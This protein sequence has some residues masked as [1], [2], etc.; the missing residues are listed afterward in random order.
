MGE[1]VGARH[2]MHVD[3]ARHGGLPVVGGAGVEDEAEK[4]VGDETCYGQRS[5]GAACPSGCGGWGFARR[6]R[7]L[8][9][10]FRGAGGD[11]G[12]AGGA[13][14]GAD[15]NE[16]VDGETGGAGLGAF[17]AID[18]SVGIATDLDRA[19]ERDES[20]ER[21]IGAEVAAPEVL[22]QHGAE[23][24]H[25]D[26]DGGGEADVA[27]EVEHF[28]IREEAVGRGH[29]VG[30]GFGGHGPD[31]EG[32]EA[33]EEILQ[34][35]ER[36]VDPAVQVEVATEEA[37]AKDGEIFGEGADGA[38][39]RAE[40]L[41]E[42]NA[43]QDEGEEEKH[44]GGMDERNVAGGE[45]E[46]RVH[47]SGDGQPAFDASGARQIEALAS[48]FEVAHPNEELESEPAVERNKDELDDVADALGAVGGEAAHQR[49]LVLDDRFGAGTH[50][51]SLKGPR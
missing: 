18:A 47:E 38:E 1:L 27:E 50:R 46:L 35:A 13:L 4:D 25:A 30:Q 16:L 37:A 23:H 49:L 48:V 8:Q 51:T 44:R 39:P 2:Q 15:L 14:G 41:F 21:A 36:D 24:E 28:D 12:H 45:E 31:D 6:Q 40:G 7:K 17:G 20:H 29:E 11:A 3:L 33:E 43:H 22:H 26:D 19:E 32:E 5:E 34:S 10:V 9:G 42:E